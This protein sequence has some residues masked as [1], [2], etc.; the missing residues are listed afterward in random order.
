M[1]HF[2]D[3]YF[4]KIGCLLKVRSAPT[5]AFAAYPQCLPV[6]HG[7]LVG[8]NKSP[9]FL[10]KSFN[11]KNEIMSYKKTYIGKGRTDSKFDIIKVTLKMEDV[12]KLQYEKEGNF[13]I[14]F[15]ISKLK[16]ADEYGRTHTCYVNTKEAD[17]P[18]TAKVEDKKHVYPKE[19]ADKI[20]SGKLKKIKKEAAGTGYIL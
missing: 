12:L 17:V 15:E 14:T 3:H 9:Y 18:A 16:D 1:F 11:L 20:K 6:F 19:V 10:G 2:C 4:A 8:N 13:Y 7:P 5:R